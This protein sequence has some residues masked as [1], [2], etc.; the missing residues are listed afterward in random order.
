MDM[1]FFVIIFFSSICYYFILA[2]TLYLISLVSGRDGSSY[3][4][5]DAG[6][7]GGGSPKQNQNVASITSEMRILSFCIFVTFSRS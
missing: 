4:D 2:M 3:G 5:V 1:I 6:G 7:N